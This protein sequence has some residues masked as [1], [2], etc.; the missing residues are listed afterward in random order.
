MRTYVLA[1]DRLNEIDN[2]ELLKDLVIFLVNEGAEGVY[3]L[4]AS[5]LIFTCDY[6]YV[7]T[8]WVRALEEYKIRDKVF[9]VL[10]EVYHSGSSKHISAQKS[11]EIDHKNFQILVDVAKASRTSLP[12]PKL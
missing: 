12:A 2:D 5:T 3:H 1:Y 6:K 9:Y 10:S 7:Y 8:H 4:V 11:E